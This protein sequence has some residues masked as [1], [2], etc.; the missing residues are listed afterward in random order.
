[1]RC[2]ECSAENPNGKKFCHQCGSSLRRQ[3]PSCGA[4]VDDGHAFCGECGTAL[5]T[6]STSAPPV[7]RGAPD[8]AVPTAERRHVSVLFVDLVSFTSLS[9]T[10]DAEAVRELLSDYFDHARTIVDRYGG[11]IEKFIGD[12]VMAVWGTPVALEDDAER[13]VRAGLDLVAA[14]ASLDVGGDHL[15]AR[16]GVVTGEAA[17]SLD[18]VNQGMVAGDVVNT[19]ARVQSVAEPGTVLVDES[20]RAATSQAISY[21]AAGEHLLKGKAEPVHLFAAAQVVAGSG[22]AMRFDGLE[23]AFT[24]RD[25]ELRLVEELF[26]DTAEQSR[27]R[28]AVVS[29]MAGVGKSRLAWEFF[30]YLDGISAVSW[31]HI[32]R[33]LS[34]GDGVAFW[35]LAEM[36]RM[37]LRVSEGDTDGDVVA[38]LRAGLDEFVDDEDERRWLLP[39]LA[40]LLGVADRVDAQPADLEQETLFAGWRLFLE[41]LAE[42]NPVV[43]VFE[44]LQHADDGLLAFVE[45]LLDWSS[46]TPLF[47]LAMTRPELL[48]EHPD[49]AIRRRNVTAL[50]L[51]PLSDDV[52]GEMVDGLVAGLPDATRDALTSRAEGIPLFAIETI[53][54]LIDRD[55]VVPRDGEYVLA[56]PA[57]EIV[58][59]DVP[60]TL[61]ALVAARLDNLPDAERRLVK[62]VAAL[63]QS[64]TPRAA[65]AVAAALGSVPADT[66]DAL[67][68]SLVRREVLS[69]HSDARSPESGQYS[70]V[71]KVMRT[72]AYDTLSR[73]DRKARH[74]AMAEHL[75]ASHDADDLAS[76]V[77]THYLDAA[78]AVPDDP[79]ADDLRSAGARH[80]ERAGDR[81]RSL[82]ATQEALRHYERAMDLTTSPVERARLAEL[83]GL[84]ARRAG[85]QER[86]LGHFRAS[87]ADHERAGALLAAARLAAHEGDVL[88]DLNRF[89]EALDRLMSAYDG[90]KG[91]PQD[92]DVAR[93]ANGIATAHSR[94][95]NAREA[96]VWLDIAIE[97]GEAAGAW[98]TLGRALNVKGLVQHDRGRPVEGYALIRAAYDLAVTHGL[99]YRA[100]MQAGNLALYRMYRDLDEARAYAE[101]SLDLAREIGDR[102]ISRS[103]V[104]ARWLVDLHAGRWAAIRDD[105]ALAD[106]ARG[107]L[108]V[109]VVSLALPHA[110]IAYWTDDQTFGLDDLDVDL[111]SQ[112]D[113]MLGRSVQHTIRAVTAGLAGD[114]ELAL[115]EARASVQTSTNYTYDSEDFPV[116]LTI[117][118]DAALQLGLW[119]DARELVAI[120]GDRPPGQ[121]PPLMRGIHGWLAGRVDA[122]KGATTEAASHLV[123][124]DRI[125]RGLGAR[126]W[127]ALALLDRAELAA[128]RG[129]DD[130]VGRLAAEAAGI[131]DDL[132]AEALGR[133]AR[134]LLPVPNTTSTADRREALTD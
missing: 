57:D 1:M 90:I 134:R 81:A 15:Q 44:D 2:S 103:A 126:F 54:M 94:S 26:H 5:A 61:Q 120:V 14:V 64:F 23:A 117:A 85:E 58:E 47:M 67:L 76:V 80:L 110:A 93:L 84:M 46:D 101:E 108:P 20:T 6:P 55:V 3:C 98:E 30:K 131:C 65:R 70:F 37:R 43:L 112:L 121:V 97:V 17:V 8:V 128:T 21:A 10:R 132:D 122:A 96:E 106:L 32:G 59:L 12:A 78:E 73:R 38:K 69:L 91:L 119:A 31:W 50:H 109:Q 42:Q 83:A 88:G 130:A 29:G 75:V 113:D 41:R 129:D 35:A 68:D 116:A 45:H 104:A 66:V 7:E 127:L 79:D 53:R 118:V 49:W 11:T 92:V 125:L 133:R 72:V 123:E 24:G 22:G 28:L 99:T 52:L 82:A 74:L 100:A 48:D 18:A 105:V 13:A 34:Y 36:I 9:E 4:A 86:A 111:D 19:A 63:G 27:T 115:Q 114:H 39:R 25:R 87:R 51:E 71:Q 107:E 33:C 60:P 16:A 102:G 89:S 77:A 95:G 40:V 124:A 62:D 56:S